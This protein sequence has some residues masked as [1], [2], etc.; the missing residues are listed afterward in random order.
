MECS[1]QGC[2]SGVISSLL[3]VVAVTSLEEPEAPGRLGDSPVF[4]VMAQSE[5]GLRASGQ[6]S[7]SRFPAEPCC[8]GHG[9]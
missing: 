1:E 4:Q 5:T 2:I 6:G 3:F 9:K 8:R 7:C